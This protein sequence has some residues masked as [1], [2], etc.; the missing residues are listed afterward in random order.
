MNGGQKISRIPLEYIALPLLAVMCLV[1]IYTGRYTYLLLVVAA[2]I[3][4]ILFIML[5]RSEK[6][7]E[8]EANHVSHFHLPCAGYLLNILFFIFLGLAFLSLLEVSYTRSI[9]FYIFFS[10]CSVAIAAEIPLVKT[11]LQAAL[12]LLK[13]VILFMGIA[14]SAQIIFPLGRGAG[15]SY[16]HIF[17]TIKPLLESGHIPIAEG[18]YSYFPAQHLGVAATSLVTA[19]DPRMVYYYQGA[20]FIS[21]CVVIVF[22]LGERINLKVG[23][24]AA[25]LL[26]NSSWILSWSHLVSQLTYAV[27][28]L[29]MI[30]ASVFYIRQDG[31][32]RF[33]VIFLLL[34]LALV[35]THQ[36]TS[37]I[38]IILLFVLLVTDVMV[39]RTLW[40]IQNLF[41]IFVVTSLAHWMYYSF[42]MS[43]LA[44]ALVDYYNAFIVE[45]GAAVT[46]VISWDV[47]PVELVFSNTLGPA[48]LIMLSV[49]GFFHFWKR[50]SL[51]ETFLTWNLIILLVLIGI[52]VFINVAY[53]I[54]ARIY[55]ILEATCLVFLAAY[56]TYW[57]WSNRGKYVKTGVLCVLACL[58]FFSS[59]STLVS[60]ETSPFKGDLAYRRTFESSH[61]YYCNSWAET[62]IASSTIYKSPGFISPESSIN[63]SRLLLTIARIDS[64]ALHKVTE[65]SYILFT[66]F[67]TEAGFL[68]R[69]ATFAKG[70]GGGIYRKFSPQEVHLLDRFDSYYDNGMCTIYHKVPQGLWRE[71][72]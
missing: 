30:L 10:L 2:L 67:D 51:F 36:Y 27:P 18:L 5:Y 34:T 16:Q 32:F 58:A 69:Q 42:A 65:D 31:K 46:G 60:F 50:L 56:A 72:P 15:D 59:A 4:T 1:L 11:R 66:L 19:I 40:C 52:G 14:C 6:G 63:F 68:T 39:S 48:I 47:A 9:Q 29:L 35:F 33:R 21:L 43:K 49:I 7:D 37:F 70:F 62:Y 54:P 13:S 38:A 23:L 17:D 64:I 24:I 55:G 26:V 71:L 12:N 8:G 28:L 61:E 53:L 57:L 41:L 45:R 20:F 3:G 25:L 44:N 22:L